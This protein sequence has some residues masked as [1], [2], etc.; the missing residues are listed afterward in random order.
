MM[1]TDT[2]LIIWVSCLFLWG[3]GII[4]FSRISV[5]EVNKKIEAS[6]HYFMST[7]D[8]VGLTLISMALAATLPCSV[9]QKFIPAVFLDVAVAQK[10]FTYPRDKIL[11]LSL[12][13]STILM[14]LSS[15]A[16]G[17]ALNV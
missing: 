13:A 14:F 5:K 12:I 4:A 16:A 15:W 8:K 1:S 7:G 2:V 9:A 10:H 17:S 11:G 6:G 3:V